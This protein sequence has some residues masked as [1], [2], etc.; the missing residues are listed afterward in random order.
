VTAEN[1]TKV[2]LM[3]NFLVR[4]V[5][6]FVKCADRGSD[7]IVINWTFVVEEDI[8]RYRKRLKEKVGAKEGKKKKV[9][10]KESGRKRSI[11]EKKK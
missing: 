4:I 10:T 7:R 11:E 6:W 1:A 5:C 9:F 3:D 2:I 8:Q